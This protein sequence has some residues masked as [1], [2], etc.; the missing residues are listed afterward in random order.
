M[1]NVD[2]ARGELEAMRARL[3]AKEEEEQRKAS[4][5]EAPTTIRLASGIRIVKRGGSDGG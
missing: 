2:K 4:E 3:I 5:P 1:S